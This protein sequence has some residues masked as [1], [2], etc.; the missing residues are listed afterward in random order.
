MI[1]PKIM[2]M[3]CSTTVLSAEPRHSLNQM[4]ARVISANISLSQVENQNQF[5]SIR[6]RLNGMK[7]TKTRRSLRSPLQ[8][9]RT[10]TMFHHQKIKNKET[11][12]LWTT[13]LNSWWFKQ[14]S[15]KRTGS[16]TMTRRR[17]PKRH[18]RRHTKQ[19]MEVTRTT[20]KKLRRRS[21]GPCYLIANTTRC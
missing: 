8:Q 6:T 12:S 13:F 18:G 14:H 10:M 7:L 9:T 1:S 21:V 17:S 20:A 19:S 15:M 5:I 11:D 16:T 3:V 2:A 4:F